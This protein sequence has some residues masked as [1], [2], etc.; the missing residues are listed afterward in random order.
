M[1]AGGGLAYSFS[2]HFQNACGLRLHKLTRCKRGQQSQAV[3]SDVGV[4]FSYACGWADMKSKPC[5]IWT[6]TRTECSLSD[7]IMKMEA[8]FNPK[9]Q[10][11]V[12]NVG[13]KG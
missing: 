4:P 8:D 6:K 5:I 11:V 7:L 3:K 2:L 13:R 10:D 12:V 1:R 9:A